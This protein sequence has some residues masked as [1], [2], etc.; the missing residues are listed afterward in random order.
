MERIN[1]SQVD[2][3]TY[4]IFCNANVKTEE[5]RSIFESI[6]NNSNNITLVKRN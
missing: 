5:V 3:K 2:Y 1:T 6:F 4:T